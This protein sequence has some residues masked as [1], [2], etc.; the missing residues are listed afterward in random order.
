MAGERE[1]G[2][3]GPLRP[4]LRAEGGGMCWC[5]WLARGEGEGRGTGWR[6]QRGGHGLRVTGA[7]EMAGRGGKEGA[8]SREVGVG[9]QDGEGA[10][11]KDPKEGIRRRDGEA[12]WRAK[13]TCLF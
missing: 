2:R 10:R 1:P 6:C 5:A 4:D 3:E 11:R 9:E 7:R 13:S 8:G 12:W